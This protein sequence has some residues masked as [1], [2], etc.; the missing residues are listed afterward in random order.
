MPLKR[1]FLLF[2]SIITILNCSSKTAHNGIETFVF[3]NEKILS[4][5]QIKYLD[6]IF[7]QHEK[8]TTNEIVIVTTPDYGEFSNNKD[9]SVDFGNKFGIGKSEYDNGVVIVFSK[10]KREVRISTG[11]GT[12]KVLTDEVSKKIIDS[13]MIPKF[14]SDLVFEGLKEGGTAIINFLDQPEHKIHKKK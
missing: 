4:V 5:K 3:D 8:R 9:F 1:F 14:K 13:I 6:S 10:I 2:V 7:R 11:N 12:E